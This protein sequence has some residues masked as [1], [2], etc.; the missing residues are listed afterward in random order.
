MAEKNAAENIFV[1]SLSDGSDIIGGL[2]KLAEDNQI[3]YGMLVSACGRI[4]DF[5]LVSS[6]PQGRME[7]MRS[8]DDFRV[9]AASGK[10]QKLS[11]GK[12]DIVVRATITRTGFTPKGGHLIRGKAAGTL[13]LGV[14]KIDLKKIIMA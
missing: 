12:L 7:T 14:R 2:Q 5:E 8:K 1:L 4:K 6:G 11:G 13:E 10:I 3:D 9:T